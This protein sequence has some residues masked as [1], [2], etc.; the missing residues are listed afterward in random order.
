MRWWPTSVTSF[1]SAIILIAAVHVSGALTRDQHLE[2]DEE[3]AR[4]CVI[5]SSAAYGRITDW[6]FANPICTEKTDGFVLKETFSGDETDAFGYVGLDPLMNRIVVAFKGTSDVHDWM[7]NLRTW[8]RYQTRCAPTA[9]QSV[10][11]SSPPRGTA[12]RGHEH[13]TAMAEVPASKIE[14]VPSLPQRKHQRRRRRGL[15]EG[16]SGDGGEGVVGRGGGTRRR[17]GGEGAAARE[18]ADGGLNVSPPVFPPAEADA[19]L[20]AEKDD[21]FFREEDVGV[22]ESSS[23]KEENYYEEEENGGE[24]QEAASLSSSPSSSGLSSFEGKDRDSSSNPDGSNSN[25]DDEDE[26]EDDFELLGNV[27]FGFC[28]YYQTLVAE[29]VADSIA[30][31]AREHPTYTV[32][33]TGHSLGAAAATV[34]AAD[35]VQ[36]LGVKRERVVLYTFGE[37]RTGDGIFADAVN[38]GVGTA[39]RLVH[40]HDIVPHLALCCHGWTGKCKPA[41]VAC[42][43]QHSTEIVYANDMDEDSSWV[44]CNDEVGEDY[45]CDPQAWDLSVADHTHYFQENVGEFCATAPADLTPY[46][47]SQEREKARWAPYEAFWAPHE[48]A[49]RQHEMEEEFEKHHQQQ[50]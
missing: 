33:V 20:E 17:E 45:A 50:Q 5:Y 32:L 21:R 8:I 39:Y 49:W 23:D 36:R 29:G 46:P 3:L 27:H 24:D 40:N 19:E 13:A 2:Y 4:L 14:R 35:L 42:P 16:S 18:P 26:D 9:L 10:A 38:D 44:V 7:T 1:Y 48:A 22:E 30:C 12:L 31:L 25:S 43:Y 37:P 11:A 28:D 15:V 6:S 47:L 34:C 41:E